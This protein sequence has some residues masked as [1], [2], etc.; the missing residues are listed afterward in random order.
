MTEILH[1]KDALALMYITIL[2]IAA[3]VYGFYI[4]PSPAKEREI[5]ADHRRVADLGALHSEIDIYYQDNQQL[6]Q[7]LAT[8]SNNDKP[9]NKIDPATQQPYEYTMTSEKSYK[10]CANFTTSSS[11][12]DPNDYDTA[13][14]DYSTYQDKLKHPA[15]HYC[16]DENENAYDYSGQDATNTYPTSEPI[17]SI[18]DYPSNFPSAS[19]SPNQGF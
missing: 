4:I 6:P 15:G 18:S 3:L 1:K 10:L 2:T 9:L 11:N 12:D 17:P 13:N 5:V 8:I 19:P 16:F 14:P 7:T